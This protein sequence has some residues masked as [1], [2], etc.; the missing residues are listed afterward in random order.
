MAKVKDNELVNY[1]EFDTEIEVCYKKNETVSVEASYASAPFLPEASV[2]NYYAEAVK[3]VDGRIIIT[4]EWDTWLHDENQREE[5]EHE[6]VVSMPW[7]LVSG[8]M[9][10]K[11]VNEI[12]T[13]KYLVHEV[14]EKEP[15]VETVTEYAVSPMSGLGVDVPFDE[16]LPF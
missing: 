7:N 14:P 5:G 8:Y 16:E 3:S 10:A 15:E 9:V 11:I 2:V 13:K 4:F 6:E 1:D 12:G